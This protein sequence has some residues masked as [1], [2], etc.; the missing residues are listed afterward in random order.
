MF[1]C[2]I[3]MIF[4]K[5]PSCLL[6]KE[7]VFLFKSICLN[8]FSNFFFVVKAQNSKDQNVALLVSPSKTSKLNF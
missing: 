8:I 6:N 7:M 4:S 1:I 3:P 5:L 2:I